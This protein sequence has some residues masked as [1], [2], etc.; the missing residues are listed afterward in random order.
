MLADNSE[1]SLKRCARDL[2]EHFGGCGGVR[3]EPKLRMQMPEMDVVHN[4][5]VKEGIL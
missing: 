5:S 2:R 3:N 4:L 1:T